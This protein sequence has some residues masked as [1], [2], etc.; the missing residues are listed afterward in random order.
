MVRRGRREALGVGQDLGQIHV[1]WLRVPVNC[2]SHR[3]MV[4]AAAAQ[5]TKIG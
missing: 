2:L 3:R 1:I 5:D 4:Y